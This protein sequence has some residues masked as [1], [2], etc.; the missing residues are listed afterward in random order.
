M[1]TTP[2]FTR[3]LDT[4]EY[5]EFNV[6]NSWLG[7]IS[8]LVSLN[9]FAG[10]FTKGLVKHEEDKY[11]YSSSME[12]LCTTCIIIGFCIYLIFRNLLN[13]LVGLSTI[14]MVLMF[15]S[16]WASSMFNFWSANQRVEFKYKALVL[17]TVANSIIKPVCSIIFVVNA[18]DR[19]TARILAI[20]LV[21][22]ISFGGL[23]LSQ[24]LKGKKFYDGK[25]WKHAIG[26]NIPLIP[27]YL[28]MT[29]L[30]SSDRIMIDNMTGADAAG[31]YSLAYSISQIMAIFNT[32]LFSTV[33]PWLYKKL[34]ENQTENIGKVAYSTLLIIAGVN[35]VLI[36]LA[37]EV[38]AIFAPLEYR[39]AIW[40]IP[41]VTISVY[42]I[43]AYTFFAVVEFH[44]EKTHYI[45]YATMS[46]AIINIVLNYVFISRYGYIA[47]G[48]TTLVCYIIYAIAHYLFS[49]KI[50]NDR[51]Q[52]IRI[53]DIKILLAITLIFM[54]SGF[55]IMLTYKVTLIRYG[56][57]IVA[58]M[59][60]VIMRNKI[61]KTLKNLLDLKRE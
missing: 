10:V 25:Y 57:L 31:I 54:I 36:M 14:K 9:L 5:G 12:G 2:I 37:P 39:E 47:A 3:L 26:F 18:E 59:L 33:E 32:A 38:V 44:F 29:L 16:I 34:K 21:D 50:C 24:M 56:I 46:G 7:I 20:V 15:V 19:V 60:V 11:G 6:Y 4:A 28:S 41:P 42:F 1:I 30:S 17:V 23:F 53:Y 51:L 45:S 8:V 27:H 48:Y 61:I 35:I 52:G 49:Q 55:G 43:F 40:V 58:F 22:L 13:E